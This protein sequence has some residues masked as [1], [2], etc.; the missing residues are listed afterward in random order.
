MYREQARPLLCARIWGRAP[1][2]DRTS[3][4]LRDWSEMM[5]QIA[6]P[7]RLTLLD[8]EVQTLKPGEIYE[9]A[10]A[11]GRVLVAD[12]WAYE[13]GA[14]GPDRPADDASGADDPDDDISG[15]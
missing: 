3:S 2:A 7:A 6:R 12:G 11:V 9:V 4:T 5:I 15:S 13:V 14:G 10:P 1:C 8:S